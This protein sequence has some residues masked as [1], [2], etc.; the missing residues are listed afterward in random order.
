MGVKISE[1]GDKMCRRCNGLM[2]GGRSVHGT[3]CS[4]LVW[5]G[6]AGRSVLAGGSDGVNTNLGA[7]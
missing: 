5:I 6:R 4:D 3:G 7:T 2:S 1:D